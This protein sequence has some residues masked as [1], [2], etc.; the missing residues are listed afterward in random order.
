MM[1]CGHYSLRGLRSEEVDE[2]YLLL[3]VCCVIVCVFM[4]L[5]LLRRMEELCPRCISSLYEKTV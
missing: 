1:I 3:I 5:A 2:E 4:W